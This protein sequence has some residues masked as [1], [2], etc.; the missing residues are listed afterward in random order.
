MHIPK[1]K[2]HNIIRFTDGSHKFAVAELRY[3]IFEAANEA[4]LG[5]IEQSFRTVKGEEAKPEPSQDMQV[6]PPS[7]LWHTVTP[8]TGQ[9]DCTAS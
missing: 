8:H 7:H 5:D 1:E 9:C 4:Q 3:T 6:S 2:L